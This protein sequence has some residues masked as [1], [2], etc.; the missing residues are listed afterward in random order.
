MSEKMSIKFTSNEAAVMTEFNRKLEAAL[1]AIGIKWVEI[2]TMEINTQPRFGALAGSAMGAVDTG[3]MRASKAH[4]ALLPDALK[5][6]LTE[7]STYDRAKVKVKDGAVTNADEIIGIFA[8]A[9][10]Y[11]FVKGEVQG[12]NIGGIHGVPSESS[13]FSS[14]G[15]D[16]TPIRPVPKQE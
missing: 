13:T 14:E 2:A 4:G 9:K 3:L 15:F 6:V 1:T 16:F 12:A 7:T 10:P 11:L 8:A 5:D